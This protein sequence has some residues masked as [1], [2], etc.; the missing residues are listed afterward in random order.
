MKRI[1]GLWLLACLLISCGERHASDIYGNGDYRYQKPDDDGN[2]STVTDA[3][4]LDDHQIHLKIDRNNSDGNATSYEVFI[5]EKTLT[6]KA[7]VGD[8]NLIF[9]TI[10]CSQSVAGQCVAYEINSYFGAKFRVKRRPN[11]L[12]KIK[13]AVGERQ[14]SYPSAYL[15]HSE[16][17]HTW[18]YFLIQNPDEPVVHWVAGSVWLP[19]FVTPLMSLGVGLVGPLKDPAVLYK[20]EGMSYLY[21]SDRTEMKGKFRHLVSGEVE[22]VTWEL[23]SDI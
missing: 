19:D 10:T 7:F 13:N 8:L 18:E 16:R 6:M 20:F 4:V 9:G 3:S 17:N 15:Q 22:V 14:V 21:Y 2:W 12:V 1:L 5:D 23:R 11:T